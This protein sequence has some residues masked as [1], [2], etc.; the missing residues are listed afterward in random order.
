MNYILGGVAVFALM[1]GT[2]LYLD[3][4][5]AIPTQEEIDNLNRA[6]P[7]GCVVHDVGSYGR[8]D[9]LLI[10][11][12]EGKQVTST[13]GYMRQQNGKTTEVDFST[14]FVIKNG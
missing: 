6:L 7:E 9:R 2:A 4:Q 10:I 1:L 12:C 8:I 11:D 3:A 14:T 5:A 13:Y